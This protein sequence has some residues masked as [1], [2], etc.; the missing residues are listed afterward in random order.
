MILH[1]HPLKNLPLAVVYRLC[2]VEGRSDA[3]SM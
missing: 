2:F 3:E 1:I